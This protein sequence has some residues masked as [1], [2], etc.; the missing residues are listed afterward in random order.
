M[1]SL[2]SPSSSDVE[3]PSDQ[4]DAAGGLEPVSRYARLSLADRSNLRIERLETPAHI[5]GLCI[6]EAR[7][8]LREDGELDLATIRRRAERR[9]PR[10]PELRRVARRPPPFCGPALWVDDPAFSIDRHVHSVQID[11]PGD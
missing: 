4:G 2:R 5:A 9:L 6:V 10:V 3:P 11:P 7:P 1:R 8:L